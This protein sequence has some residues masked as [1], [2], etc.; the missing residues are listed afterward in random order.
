MRKGGDG[1]KPPMGR[2]V[3]M[4]YD[5]YNL[6]GKKIDSSNDRGKVFEFV[7]GAGQVIG[8]WD[9]GVAEMSKGE[10]CWIIGGYDEA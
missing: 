8:A 6:D 7:L 10:E 1:I 5:L 3:Q 2:K 4:H 9:K